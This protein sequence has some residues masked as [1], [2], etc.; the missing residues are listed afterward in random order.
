M[1][2]MG[3]RG[4]PFDR[5]LTDENGRPYLGGEGSIDFS[6]SHSGG[7]TLCVAIPGGRVGIDVEKIQK[8]DFD[9]YRRFIPGEMWR[10]IEEADDRQG[11]FFKTWTR[12][13][14][15]AKAHGTGLGAGFEG[16]RFIEGNAEFGGKTWWLREIHL[17]PD[18]SCH[19]A[20][21]RPWDRIRLLQRQVPLT[22][23]IP[24]TANR[25]EKANGAPA[26]L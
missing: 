14:A 11:L 7:F 5:L 16:L 1:E 4:D 21:D 17:H 26:R 6:L 13:E 22:A 23:P 8:V 3:F 19:L 25:N 18:Y 2:D 10:E 15:V 20:V 12:L 24:H 9:D